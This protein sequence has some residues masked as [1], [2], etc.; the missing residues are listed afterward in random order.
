[1]KG[2]GHGQHNIK[3]LQENNIEYNINKVYEND[4]R[5]GMCLVIR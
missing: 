3:F 5:I 4:V 1:M 2:G